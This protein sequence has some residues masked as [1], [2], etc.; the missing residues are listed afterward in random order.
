MSKI[1]DLSIGLEKAVIDFYDRAF[2]DR[3]RIAPYG[4]KYIMVPIYKYYRT[5]K[6]KD[7]CSCEEC[8]NKH[9]NWR[10]REVGVKVIGKKKI[11]VPKDFS[12]ILKHKKGKPQ[13]IKFKRY[14]PLS[15]EEKQPLTK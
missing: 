5:I 11:K 1:K 13:V 12:D 8:G 4:Y 7:Y 6:Y 9:F 15:V 3:A 2:L 14:S 10:T